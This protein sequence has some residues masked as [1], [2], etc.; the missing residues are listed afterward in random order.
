MKPKYMYIYR[1]GNSFSIAIASTI[2]S[3]QIS[4]MTRHTLH[5]ILPHTTHHIFK[6]S[7]ALLSNC[8]KRSSYIFYLRT[9][10]KR[11]STLPTEHLLQPSHKRHHVNVAIPTMQHF[12][13][14]QSTISATTGRNSPITTRHIARE[15]LIHRPRTNS[16]KQASGN[17]FRRFSYTSTRTRNFKQPRPT[18]HQ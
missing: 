11:P 3:G 1:K 6:L 16:P 9:S 8:H 14:H 4:S 17:Y 10:T 5:M 15:W 13:V 7:L 18:K 2:A 12:H